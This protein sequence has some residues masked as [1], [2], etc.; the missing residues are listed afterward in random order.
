MAGH[1]PDNVVELRIALHRPENIAQRL[2]VG[3]GNLETKFFFQQILGLGADAVLEFVA[4]EFPDR[5]VKFHRL[6]GAHAQDFRR[7]Q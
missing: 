4:E 7:R 2:L 6:R 5:A 3:R 1:E